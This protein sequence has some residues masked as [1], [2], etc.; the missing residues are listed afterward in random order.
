M[1]PLALDDARQHEE[2]R[3]RQQRR[4][5]GLGQ[6]AVEADPVPEAEH[7]RGAR[8]PRAARHADEVELDAI[9][10]GRRGERVEQDAVALVLLQ[11]GDA[12]RPTGRG[13]RRRG[14]NA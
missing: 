11:A 9:E 12:E 4:D 8:A 1:K 10:G 14:A 6:A 5:L 13:R 2:V 7:G 3:A